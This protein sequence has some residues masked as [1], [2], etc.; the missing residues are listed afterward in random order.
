[1]AETLARRSIVQDDYIDE[2]L[3]TV[4]ARMLRVRSELLC[5][6]AGCVIPAPATSS[7]IRRTDL[8]RHR[9]RAERVLRFLD[10][11]CLQNLTEGRN[12]AAG[13]C[14][15]TGHDPYNRKTTAAHGKPS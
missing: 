15:T 1:M 13:Q 3:E 11:K 2:V 14:D 4:S 5:K 6:S 12:N 10:R 7:R 8:D 9:E